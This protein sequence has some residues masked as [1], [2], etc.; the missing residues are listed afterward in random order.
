MSD[1]DALLRAICEN[2]AD[3]LPRLVYADW[4]EEN[5]QPERAA[6]IRTEI[7]IYRRPEW[8]AER[9]RYEFAARLDP[10]W[11]SKQPWAA[12][13]EFPPLDAATWSGVPPVRRGFP[14]CL[15]VV[16]PDIL[17]GG[18]P[19]VATRCPVERVEFAT[20]PPKLPRLTKSPALQTITGLQF[21]RGTFRAP[22]M[23]AFG[24]EPVVGHLE[25]LSFWHGS[26]SPAVLTALLETPLFVNLTALG[27]NDHGSRVALALLEG[28]EQYQPGPRLRA[29]ELWSAQLGDDGFRLL[30]AA[31]SLSGLTRLHLGSNHVSAARMQLLAESP[32]FANLRSLFLQVNPLGN[33][34]AAALAQSPHLPELRVLDLAYCQVGDDGIRAILESPLAE[35][36]VL[37]NLTGSPA[38]DEMKQTLKERMGERVRL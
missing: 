34:G 1:H 10:G 21:R 18:W 2:P 24:N 5:G 22:V 19:Q 27:V 31:R 12:D 20:P 37:L 23:T 6:F 3:D 14:W 25:E 29:L 7:D 8:D 38:S 4:L 11:L 33:S 32:T 16:K 26:L 15:Q 13:P 30:A 9:A 36:L 28:I 17:F 35:R